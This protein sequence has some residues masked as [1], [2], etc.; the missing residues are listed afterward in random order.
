MWSGCALASPG[1][2]CGSDGVNGTNHSTWSS[3]QT[4][5]LFK[6]LSGSLALAGECVMSSP[7]EKKYKRRNNQLAHLCFGCPQ[8]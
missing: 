5:A 2:G 1:R 6:R 4:F 3:C 8:S 7:E